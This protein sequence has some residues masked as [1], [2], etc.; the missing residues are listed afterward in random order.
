VI[1]TTSNLEVN[2]LGRPLVVAVAIAI[3]VG[4]AVPVQLHAQTLGWEGETGAFVTPLAYTASSETQKINPVVAYQMRACHWSF[5]KRPRSRLASAS[6]W[7]SATRT[8]FMLTY[9]LRVV[10]TRKA[11]LNF[12]FGVGQICG[13]VYGSGA[14]AID[15]KARHQA[16]FQVSYSF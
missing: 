15:V 7:S 1:G 4:L 16:G 11:K 5:S 6:D 2:P 9:D 14:N 3:I 8:N 12:D 10:P 13:Q